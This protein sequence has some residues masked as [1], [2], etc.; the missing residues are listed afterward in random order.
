MKKRFMKVPALLVS[1]L[2]V[3]SL[4]VSGCGT[5]TSSTETGNK[6]GASSDTKQPIL[7]GFSSP[8]TGSSAK[9]GQDMLNGAKLAMDEINA[10][11]GIL[12]RQIEIIEGDDACDP[13]QAVQAANKLVGKN[14]VAAVGYYC[15]GAANATL[16]VY[17]RAGTPVVLAAVSATNL[18]HQGFTNVFRIQGNN[19]QQGQVA[20]ELMLNQLGGKKIA[21]VQDNTSY[22]R[23]LAQSTVD[24]AKKTQSSATVDVEEITPGEK[25]FSAVV[26]KLKQFAPDATYFTGYYAEGSLLVKQMRNMG[27]KTPFLAGDANNDPAFAS[28]AGSDAE[29]VIMTSPPMVET[30]P[31]AAK[32]ISSYKNK[33]NADP[34]AYAVYAYDGINLI[35]DAIKRANSTDKDKLITALKSTKD[36]KA[37]TSTINFDSNGDLAK[38]GYL[39]VVLKQ[40]KF[41]P[42]Q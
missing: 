40:G 11:G 5:G 38:P 15:S 25:D 37:I 12:G 10:A 18:T 41:V 39:A 20:A 8:L 14:V 2:I 33:Y 17:Q 23:G 34:G 4:A 21:V 24:W 27:I 31:S 32:F 36:F 6:Q 35:A 22:A 7:I 1:G 30:L 26:T 9:G 13:Q 3:M 42:Y 16:P 29:G 19:D 28:V